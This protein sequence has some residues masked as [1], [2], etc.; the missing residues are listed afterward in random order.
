MSPTPDS[1]KTE[2][3]RKSAS[4]TVVTFRDTWLA[5]LL[6]AALFGIIIASI[7][8]VTLYQTFRAGCAISDICVLQP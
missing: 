1:T 2:P 5:L 6:G 4:R 3:T 7:L 8:G